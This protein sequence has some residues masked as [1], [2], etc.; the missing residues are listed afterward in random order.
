MFDLKRPKE[1]LGRV[2]ALIGADADLEMRIVASD[3]YVNGS[4][5]FRLKRERERLNAWLAVPGNKELLYDNPRNIRRF[6][7]DEADGPVAFGKLAWY[8]H[9]ILPAAGGD[10]WE[11]PYSYV[12]MLASATVKAYDDAEYADGVSEAVRARPQNKRYLIELL[13]INMDE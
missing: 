13:A 9:L 11:P 12:Q 10:R 4:V 7:D 5:R 6:N 3:D 1:D 2:E 8:P